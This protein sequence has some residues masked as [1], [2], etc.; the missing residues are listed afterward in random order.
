MENDSKAENNFMAL[1]ANK[2]SSRSHNNRHHE[3]PSYNEIEMTRPQ[4]D[5]PTGGQGH[6]HEYYAEYALTPADDVNW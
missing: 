2:D 1:D 6:G 3:L 5:L 4:V